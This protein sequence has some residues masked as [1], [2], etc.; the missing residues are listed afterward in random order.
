MVT[1]AQIGCR[2]IISM[3]QMAESH[4]RA[5]QTGRH[6]TGSTPQLTSF[7]FDALSPLMTPYTTPTA[8]RGSAAA[9][10]KQS[11]STTMV[12]PDR[13]PTSDTT[14]PLSNGSSSATAISTVAR[15]R[16]VHSAAALLAPPDNF[17]LPHSTFQ[18]HPRI[19][20]QAV[21]V[22]CI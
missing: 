4:N 18:H 17:S 22:E 12:S 13:V 5:T 1:P 11:A 14:L 20:V 15:E 21:A 9:M 16:L 19:E 2:M 6:A 8:S 10:S 7:I 3:Q